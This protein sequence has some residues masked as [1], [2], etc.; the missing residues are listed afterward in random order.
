MQKIIISE[1]G[2]VSRNILYILGE[3]LDKI[4]FC[5]AS[6][7]IRVID[8]RTVLLIEVEDQYEKYLRDL[9]EEKIAEV[10]CISYKYELLS[11]NVLTV[12][13][14]DTEREILIAEII[15]ADLS[16]D[17]AY[18][19]NE[20]SKDEIY[21]FDGFYAF[22]MSALKEKWKRISESVP[23]TFQNDQ[24]ADFI[25]YIIEENSET[26]YIRDREAYNG[27]HKILHRAKLIEEDELSFIREII[28]SGAKE[29]M[30]L[31]GVNAF[32]SAFLEK[33]YGERVF[34]S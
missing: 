8:K 11:E 22:R 24:L 27:S 6:S 19:S 16:D 29:V 23:V 30:C 10:I 13:L 31:T 2:D 7:G 5:G 3:I 18:V 21:Q 1:K 15:A 32:E 28:F 14:T 26:I 34:F 25:G 4:E 9:I 33:Y 20:L 17:I 12:S